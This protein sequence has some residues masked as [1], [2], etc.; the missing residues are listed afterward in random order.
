[1]Y[2]SDVTLSLTMLL[3]DFLKKELRDFSRFYLWK[4][5]VFK[6]NITCTTT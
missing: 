6:N 1:M 2:T 5:N 3:R 4:T